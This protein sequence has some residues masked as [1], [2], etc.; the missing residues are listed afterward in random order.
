MQH[1]IDINS[2]TRA[3]LLSLMQQAQ[4]FIV[5]PPK[6]VLQNQFVANLFF[7]PSTR[8]RCS[9]EIAAK[10]LGAQV[11][12]IDKHSSSLQKG[13]T[14]LDTALNLRAMGI[15]LFVIRH[16]DNGV[17]AQIA[18]A[19]GHDCAVI[20]AGCGTQQH[21][22]QAVLDMLTIQQHKKDFSS[23][24]VSIIGDMINSRVTHS[25]VAA[26][27]MLG[28]KEI[29]LIAPQPL[30]PNIQGTSIKTFTDLNSGLQNVD[31]VMALRLQKERM[32]KNDLPNQNDFFAT[33][34]LTTQR[35]QLAKPDA[36][37]MHPGPMNRGVEITDAV[38]DGQQS[39]I[40][41]QAA[42]GVPARMAIL[43]R[44]FSA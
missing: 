19:L 34:G 13:E 12:N 15:K 24:T 17:V 44:C 20:N 29:R 36:I 27:Q 2:L 5:H 23:L 32:H 6:P 4:D 8:T 37:V 14:P 3:E 18:S 42:N 40:L 25:D 39:V 22:S 10:K 11:I 16:H 35:L 38:A 33:F 21:P 28:V 9:F 41:Q 31:V 30:Q 7:E 43:M 1:F 26:L